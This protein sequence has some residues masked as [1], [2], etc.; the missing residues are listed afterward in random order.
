[1]IL[2]ISGTNRQNNVTSRVAATYQQLLKESGQESLLLNLEDL[3]IDFVFNND[4]MGNSS[5]AFS[6][7][8]K[9]FIV[10]ADKLVVIVPEYNGG[11]TGVLKAFID[12]IWPEQLYGKKA[13]LVGVASGRAGNLRGLD[14]LTNI[15][16]YLEITVLP[17]KVPISS[18]DNL[19]DDNGNLTDS[20]TLD[21]LRKQIGKFLNF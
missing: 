3:P 16:H 21:S 20:K 6:D 9:R 2:V 13:A 15:F 12:G 17:F 4:V 8:V 19:L 7:I 1:M 10:P 11:M 14:H 18:V 5:P